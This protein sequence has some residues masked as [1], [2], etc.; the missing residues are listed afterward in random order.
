M[1]QIYKDKK[2]FEYLK[3]LF[4]N[5]VCLNLTTNDLELDKSSITY[6]EL[7]FYGNEIFGEDI[8]LTSLSRFERIAEEVAKECCYDPAKE[9]YESLPN[10]DY[11]LDDVAV[12]YFS[13]EPKSIYCT[14]VRKWLISAVA[15]TYEPGCK[16]NLVL[17]LYSFNP[18][19]VFRKTSWFQNLLPKENWFDEGSPCKG[20]D[21][22]AVHQN[23][24]V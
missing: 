1:R 12:K 5:R 21:I 19:K 18:F 23:K 16:V 2:D 8:E 9:Y 7:Y 20:D 24:I 11:N 6:E 4:N 17:V 3:K 14:M 10:R 22:L 13:V 15:R